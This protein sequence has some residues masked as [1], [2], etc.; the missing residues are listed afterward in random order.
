MK[1][2][3]SYLVCSLALVLIFSNCSDDVSIDQN[4]GE[5]LIP[6]ASVFDGGPGKDGIPAI[7]NPEFIPPSQVDFLDDNDLIIGVKSG[8]EVRGYSHVILDYHEIVNDDVNGKKIALTYCPLTGTAIGWNRVVNGQETTFG[9]SGFLYN[10]NLMPFDRATDSYWS[11]MRLDCV[12]GDLIGTKI[13]TFAVIET[14]W[15]T[16]QEMY[17]DSKVLSTNTGFARSYGIY[18]YGDYRVNDNNL[19]FPIDTDDGRVPRKERVLGIEVGSNAKAYRFWAFPGREVTVLQDD[20][21]GKSLVLA[22]SNDL[23]FLVAYERKLRDGTE[24]EFTSIQDQLPII[25]EDNEGNKWDIFGHAVEGSRKGET[26]PETSSYI[27]YW[28]SWGTF[29]PGLELYE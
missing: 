9:V 14:T 20:F 29:H 16:W 1:N 2:L 8:D 13:E 17:P 25:M 22:G 3:S 6:S 19:I 28:F 23:N 24:L 26:L 7:S 5:W 15:K 11:Q 12:N 21:R 4:G 10:T 27:G 18:P